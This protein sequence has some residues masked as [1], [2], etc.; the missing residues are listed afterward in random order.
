MIILSFPWSSTLAIKSLKFDNKCTLQGGDAA[1]DSADGGSGGA[2]PRA[3]QLQQEFRALA[4]QHDRLL[5]VAPSHE[6]EQEA[7]NIVRVCAGDFFLR[8]LSCFEG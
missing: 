6:T 1:G 2:T 8:V 7:D 5:Q 4:E 3:D